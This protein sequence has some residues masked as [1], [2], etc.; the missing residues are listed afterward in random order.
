MTLRLKL[1]DSMLN[2]KWSRTLFGE[3][4]VAVRGARAPA[5]PAAGDGQ[6]RRSHCDKYRPP[7]QPLHF[8]ILTLSVVA[9]LPR[10]PQPTG[11][12]QP[13]SWLQVLKASAFFLRWCAVYSDIYWQTF[14][15]CLLPPPPRRN[16]PEVSNLCFFFLL[17]RSIRCTFRFEKFLFVILNF[18][19]KTFRIKKVTS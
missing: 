19:V 3:R 10:L 5:P 6:P 2:V 7:R 15:K 16:I 18:G 9:L 11:S 8:H 4:R 14:R 12:S 1:T 13:V 17:I